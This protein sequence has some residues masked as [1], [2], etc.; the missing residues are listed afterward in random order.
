MKKQRAVHAAD[1][2]GERAYLLLPHVLLKSEAYRTAS[3]RARAALL[4]IAQRFN[5][6]NNGRICISAKEMAEALNCW[7]YA[8]NS[9]AIGELV[10]RGIVVI[11]RVPPR[12]SRLSTEYRLTFVSSGPEGKVRPATNEYRHWRQGDAGS[13]SKRHIGKSS[14]AMTTTETPLSVAMTAMEGSETIATVTTLA[15]QIDGNEPFFRSPSVATIAAHISSHGGGAYFPADLTM[16]TAGGENDLA[17]L[18]DLALAQISAA[19]VGEQGRIARAAKIPGGT[20]SKFLAGKGLPPGHASA[21]LHLLTEDNGHDDAA[22]VL[23]R[24]REPVA[25]FWSGANRI[26]KTKLAQDVGLT[27]A[28]VD[29]YVRGLD[30]LPF[31]KCTAL[32]SACASIGG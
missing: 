14:L 6:Y 19:P 4:A 16:E 28:Q 1:N 17:R 27:A 15:G 10:A 5:G 25:A 23:D 18:R 32:R 2:G 7:N 20:F 9:V 24:M 12:G 8:S 30:V 31:T 29:R 21:L 11:E 22:A 13:V 26:G 3:F